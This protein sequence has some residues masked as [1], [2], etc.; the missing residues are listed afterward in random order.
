MSSFITHNFPENL[1]LFQNKTLIL[2][3]SLSLSCVHRTWND[4]PVVCIIFY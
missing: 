1:K 2:C 3:V 4:F